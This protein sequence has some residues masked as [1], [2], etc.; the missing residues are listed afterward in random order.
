MSF[1]ESVPSPKIA[2]ETIGDQHF[3]GSPVLLPLAESDPETEAV[4]AFDATDKVASAIAGL[5]QVETGPEVTKSP[6]E[7]ALAPLSELQKKRFRVSRKDIIVATILGLVAGI[8]VGGAWSSPANFTDKLKATALPGTAEIV[9][10]GSAKPEQ[11]AQPGPVSADASGPKLDE[12]KDQ[13]NAIASELSSLQQNMKGLAE[14]QEQIRESQAQLAQTQ[15]RF[16]AAQTQANLKQ[17]AQPG[18]HPPQV[19]KVSRRDDLYHP[20]KYI[21]Y[22]NR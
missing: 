21:L 3:P 22:G 10:A 15:S 9:F 12:M 8:A 5:K 17:S 2:D 14:G 19:R 11:S 4:Y 16:S 18:T 7:P 1:F 6:L 13:L 20:W